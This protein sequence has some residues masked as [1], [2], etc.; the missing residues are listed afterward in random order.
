MSEEAKV[1]KAV[2][3]DF[4]DYCTI[5]QNRFG[6][7]NEFYLHKVINRFRSNTW[8]DVPVMVCNE[9]VWHP[10]MEDVVSCICCGVQETKVFKFRLSDVLP[11]SSSGWN[12]QSLRQQLEAAQ[13]EIK[14]LRAEANENIQLAAAEENWQH[15]QGDDY[16]SY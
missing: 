15:I 13:K 16:G 11:P 3:L 9:E 4:G 14:T 10:D 2:E 5:E 1:M 12:T 6:A 7:P 8:V